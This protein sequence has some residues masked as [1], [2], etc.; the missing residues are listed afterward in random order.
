MPFDVPPRFRPAIE[1]LEALAG[2]ERYRAAFVF[3]SL[4]RGDAG[5]ASDLDANVVTAEPVECQR[6]NHPRIGGVKLDLTF[7]SFEQLR[8]QTDKEIRRSQRIPMVAESVVLFDKD[9]RVSALRDEARR[10]ER[11]PV[12]P[13]EHDFLQFLI[14]HADD[15]ARRAGDPAAALLA[16]S[17]GL[18]DLLGIHYR[19]HGRWWVSNKRRLDDLRG[20]DRPLAE[21]VA[22]FVAT[23]EVGPKLRLWERIVARVLEPLG[24]RKP[25]EA[26]SCTCPSCT[27]DLAALRHGP[28]AP[29]SVPEVVALLSGAPFPW[30]VA[31]GRAIDL[32]VG[33]E[34]RPHGDTDVQVLRRDQLAVQAALAGWELHAA[35]P[36]GQ[37]RPLAP[38]ELL[39]EGI[40]DV[41]CRRAPDAFGARSGAAGARSG[42]AGAR[43]GA[44][45]ARGHAPWALQL[46]FSPAEDGRW[47]FRRDPRITRP[48]ERFG[49]R[50]ADGVPYVAPEIQ[51]L[52]K[53]RGLLAKD[54]ADFGAALPLLDAEARSWLTEA[55]TLY[56]PG[57]PWLASLRRRG[58]RRPKWQGWLGQAGGR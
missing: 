9:G 34:T 28:W 11:K 31:G 5:D 52:F 25:I 51:L 17:E 39:G 18:A 12:D 1:A 4:A 44:A 2:A 54:Q 15:K 7:R 36:P 10:V 38:G 35:D 56:L 49:R 43:S 26:T 45:G 53:A 21:L 40:H 23:A 29:L 42:A 37:L 30:W 48:I 27:A 58:R 13:S 32:F 55:L 41:W 24:G 50:T 14:Q 3:G 57:H 22:A 6:I 47:I 8:E 19:L 46:M 16:M 33:R 20:W